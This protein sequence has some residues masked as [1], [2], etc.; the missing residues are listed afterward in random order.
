MAS[1]NIYI[2]PAATG[3]WGEGLIAE[4]QAQ[5]TQSMT[6]GPTVMYKRDSTLHPQ[7]KACEW[8]LLSGSAYLRHPNI[9]KST[10]HI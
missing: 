5:A 8:Y 4:T 6:A 9:I 7:K 10:L 2:A 3:Q 1:D